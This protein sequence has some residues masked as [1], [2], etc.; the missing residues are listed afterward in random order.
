ME[1]YAWGVEVVV[2]EGV[3]ICVEGEVGMAVEAD[4]HVK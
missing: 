4:G 1:N 2:W 3:C